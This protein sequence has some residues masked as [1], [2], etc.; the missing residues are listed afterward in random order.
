MVESSVPIAQTA[1]VV[2]RSASAG[3]WLG[4]GIAAGVV[5]GTAAAVIAYKMYTNK[6]A[7]KQASVTPPYTSAFV[8]VLTLQELSA[9]F[10][11]N[12]EK[13]S[14]C[15]RMVIATPTEETLQGVGLS[16][17]DAISA[18]NSIIQFF[19]DNAE[20]T[21]SGLRVV[22]YNAIDTNLEAL[23]AEKDGMIVITD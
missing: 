2:G 22:R 16:Q 5:V 3:V 4:V 14:T 12:R 11:E 13:Y 19:Y 20:K 17:T 10:K 8:D 9:W 21:A 1:A 23:L 6:K 7:E 15:P 18:D